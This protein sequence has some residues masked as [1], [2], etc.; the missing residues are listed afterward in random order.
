MLQ[1]SICVKIPSKL[2]CMDFKLF[3]A[4]DRKLKD[5][6]WLKSN[7]T[8]S[9]SNFQD[10]TRISFGSLVVFNDD[11]VQPEKGFGIHAHQ[12]MEIISVML[13]GS[14]SHKDDMGYNNVVKEGSVQIMSAGSGLYHEEYNVG[15]DDVNFLQIW[16][17]PKLQNIKPRYQFRHFPK[18][19]RKNKLQLI[20][21]NEEGMDH[22][23]INQNAKLSLGYFDETTTINYTLNPINKCIFIFCI[24]GG[25]DIE[26]KRL[27][28]RDAIGIWNTSEFTL[29]CEKDSEFI[30][31]ETP[32]NQK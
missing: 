6:G 21:S 25:L 7:F 18:H 19:T 24:E 4:S 3:P 13:N 1:N 26:K 23:W 10:P 9:F 14:M 2:I 15:Q 12:N 11:F 30:I 8:F 17:S 20:V 16:I 29:K 31:I 5:L 22:C 28:K 27:S 32:I